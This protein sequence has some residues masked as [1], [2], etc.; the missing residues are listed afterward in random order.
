MSF[1]G[2]EMAERMIGIMRNR[3]EQNAVAEIKVTKK[4]TIKVS[5]EN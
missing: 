1:W 4:Y 2:A 3:L 5:T